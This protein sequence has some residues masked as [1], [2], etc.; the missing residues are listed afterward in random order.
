MAVCESSSR[1][2]SFQLCDASERS[3]RNQEAINEKR[4]NPMVLPFLYR[5]AVASAVSRNPRESALQDDDVLS[6]RTFLALANSELNLLTFN[7][8]FEA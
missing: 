4:Q 7:Q 8:G 3:Y 6:L 1:S 5:L 2:S